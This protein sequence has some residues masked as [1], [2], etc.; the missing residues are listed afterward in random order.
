M[1]ILQQH[2]FLSQTKV[3]NEAIIEIKETQ[4]KK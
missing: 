1:T 3:P 2:L 4:E